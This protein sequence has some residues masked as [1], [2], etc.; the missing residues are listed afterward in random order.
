M[1]FESKTALVTGAGQGIGRA[2]AIML[3]QQGAKVV[4]NDINLESAQSVAKEIDT[5]LGQALAIKA[6]VS[7]ESDVAEMVAKALKE[8]SSLEILVNNAGIASYGIP[9]DQ[10]SAE[11][12]DR[13]MVINLRGTF[14]CSR[15]VLSHMKQQRYG[16]I[17]NISS[18]AGQSGGIK[19]GAD[20]SASKAGI[21]ALTKKLALEVA[22]SNINVNAVAP[23]TTETEMIE[24]MPEQQRDGLRRAIPLGRFGQ[25]EDI[26]HAVC[27]LASEEASFITGATLDVNGGLLMR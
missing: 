11:A 15:A 9:T 19:V 5:L 14:L 8:F 22:G 17:I 2:I 13:S 18:L 7:D 20:Y 4:V 16:K 1:R 21:I 10:L 12:W 6:D 23:A 26:A 24:K 25:P 27:F 3:A